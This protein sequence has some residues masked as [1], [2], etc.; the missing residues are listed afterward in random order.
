[1]AKIVDNSVLDGALAVVA[2]ATT[3]TLCSSQPANYAAIS[4]VALADAAMTGGD[5]SIADGDTSGRKTTVAA[6]AGEA[7]DATGTGTH[8]CLDDGTTLLYVTT[9]DSIA[10][11]SGGS[12]DYPSWD[13]E[14]ADPT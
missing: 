2:T 4:G 7:V 8:V 3:M 1:M 14:F 9:T 5:Y 6:Q 12:V 11:T 10:V 13:V